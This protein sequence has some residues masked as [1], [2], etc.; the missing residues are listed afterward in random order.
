MAGPHWIITNRRV[1]PKGGGLP[2]RV[3]E[4]IHEALPVFRVARFDPP[5]SASPSKA[6]LL[7]AVTFVPDEF[8]TN[9]RDVHARDN[10]TDFK[11]S[12]RLFLSLY[13]QMRDAPAGKGD[14]MFLMHGFNYAWVDALRELHRAQKIYCEPTESPVSQML[15]FSWPSHGKQLEYLSD[16]QIAQP[17]GAL[18]GRVFGKAV[19]FHTE[20]FAP[21]NGSPAFC[22]RKF[23]LA[24]HSMGNQVLE[25]FMRSIREY[26]FL[27]RGI[28]GE[29]LLLNA[30]ADW[31]ALEPLAPLYELPEYAQRIHVYNH[32]SDDA[33]AIS[34]N[35]KNSRKRLGRHG[36]RD[37]GLIPPRNIVVDCSKLDGAKPG[38]TAD[39]KDLAAAA[40]V[41][42]RS[43][44]SMRERMFDHWG[45][46]NRAEVIAD[47]YAVLRGESAITIPR[48]EKRDEKLFRLVDA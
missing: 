36:P 43:S 45:Y 2:E 41:L 25:E 32:F 35:T 21:S 1:L 5:A 40:R 28:F 3:D 6:E 11:G 14:T 17:S 47:I 18:L 30:D 39:S 12:S 48:R 33:L 27:R 13:Q 44:V 26:A 34:E 7:D 37:L 15:Y 20:F 46:L 29:T 4:T 42:G 38:L 16:Q 8:V 9:Y 22:G 19:R 23:H 10:P 24:A 31:T